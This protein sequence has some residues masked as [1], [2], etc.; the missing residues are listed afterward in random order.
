MPLEGFVDRVMPIC[1]YF[2][3]FFLGGGGGG[4]GDSGVWDGNAMISR[5]KDCKLTFFQRIP[6]IY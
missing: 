2:S 5:C 4:V 1:Y 6:M 3:V